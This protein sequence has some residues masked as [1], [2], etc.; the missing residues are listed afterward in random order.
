MVEKT[1]VDA[2]KMC[3]M[4]AR[5]EPVKSNVSLAVRSVTEDVL[6]GKFVTDHMENAAM[7]AVVHLSIIKAVHDGLLKND[8]YMAL[9]ASFV[10]S[11]FE[12]KSSSVKTKENIAGSK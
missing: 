4:E 12:K 6:N 10:F 9:V 5:D 8:S 1:V 7:K 3:A 2:I 11:Y